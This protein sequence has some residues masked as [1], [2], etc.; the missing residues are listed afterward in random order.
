[1]TSSD[2]TIV[3]VAV[4]PVCVYLTLMV[5]VLIVQPFDVPAGSIAGAGAV[6]AVASIAFANFL[7]R[8][9]DRH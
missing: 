7:R 6:V 9:R 4:L 2:K 5:A 3:A 1:M 8:R